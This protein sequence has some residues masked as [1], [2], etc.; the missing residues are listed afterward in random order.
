MGHMA[1][2]TKI[3]VATAPGGQNKSAL[4]EKSDNPGLNNELHKISVVPLLFPY[5]TDSE[6]ETGNVFA[7]AWD[8]WM[9]SGV[10]PILDGSLKDHSSLFVALFFVVVLTLQ[11]GTHFIVALRILVLQARSFLAPVG[12]R[13]MTDF[14]SSVA[15]MCFVLF[16]HCSLA[17]ANLSLGWAVAQQACYQFDML[18][19]VLALT[20]ILHTDELFYE[21]FDM[22]GVLPGDGGQG[23]SGGQ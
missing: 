10:Q 15:C 23:N 2:H 12:D 11:T 5:D 6:V 17:V 19:N 20:F 4:L 21:I 7:Q 9:H 14:G 1:S 3:H 8:S 16:V 18:V 13:P 22:A